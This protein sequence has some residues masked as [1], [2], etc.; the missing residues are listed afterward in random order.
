MKDVC[1]L[2]PTLNE[3]GNIG[4]VIEG[5]LRQGFTNVFVIDGR[6]TDRTREIAERM[7]A[8]V[9]IQTGKG[10]G[11][12]IREAFEMID[13][14][15]VVIVD[16]DGSY[17]PEEVNRLLEPIRR[18]IADH[19]VGNRFANFEK[20][21][22]T[23]LNLFGNKV[24]NFFFRLVY[25]VE[26][27]D[28]LSGY[29]ALTKEVYKNV[30]LRK[31]GFEVETELTVETI[32]KGFRI[33]EVPITYRKRGGKTKL[34]PL[35]DGFKIGATI[36]G[37]LKRYSPGRYFYFIGLA[38]VLSG[39]LI[40]SYVVYDWFKNVTH[41]LLAILTALLIISGL[42]VIVFGMISDFLFRSNVELRKEIRE[43]REEIERWKK[44]ERGHREK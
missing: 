12:A 33:L 42:Q 40:G 32:A 36:Y 27:H 8:K 24:L 14:D 29:R 43:I 10:K 7:G 35:K 38:L 37:M 21:A 5:F 2:I 28:I 17:M 6:S 9:V 31:P 11:Q 39:I 44:T 3:E 26:L 41:Y 34:H 13:S 22:F 4:Y 25:G 20:G 23:R 1:I 18:G 16:G 30:E 15:V 19:V